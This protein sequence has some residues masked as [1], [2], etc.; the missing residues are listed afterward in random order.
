MTE[1]S[2]S[3]SPATLTDAFERLA[4][5]LTGTPGVTRAKVFGYA[6]LKIH[7][8][9]FAATSDGH[10][11]VKLSPERIAELIAQGQ[12]QSFIGYGKVMRGWI[13]LATEDAGAW[14]GYAEE[15]QRFITNGAGRE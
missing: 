12:G 8:K 4:Y 6:A 1:Q 9:V 3:E 14:L 11:I 5:A 15:A 2:P 10:L 13:Q 7:G